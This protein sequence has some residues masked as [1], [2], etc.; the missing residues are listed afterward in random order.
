MNNMLGKWVTIPEE[1]TN[2][3]IL[4]KAKELFQG[5]ELEGFMVG[6]FCPL[7]GMGEW[8]VLGVVDDGQEEVSVLYSDDNEYLPSDE[9]NWGQTM[10]IKVY[11]IKNLKMST[12]KIAAQASHACIGLVD[13]YGNDLLNS[14]VVLSVSRTKFYELRNA[15]ED[16]GTF[17]FTQI[18]HGHTEVSKGTE[19]AFAYTE[20]FKEDE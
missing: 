13:F 10:K 15:I 1:A 3:E 12:G 9:L 6:C 8:Q 7:E 5:Y 17:T 19:T 20:D 4:D 2:L 11:Y 14:V 16:E 18:D